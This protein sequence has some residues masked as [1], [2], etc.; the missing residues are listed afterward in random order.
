MRVGRARAALER[1]SA[2]LAALSPFATLDRGYAIVR[3]AEG[4]IV[5]E[6]ASTSPGDA[7]SVHLHR[8]ALDVTV[9]RVRDSADG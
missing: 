4:G 5:R 8:G 1:S 9:E 3:D 6:A 2:G 7:L